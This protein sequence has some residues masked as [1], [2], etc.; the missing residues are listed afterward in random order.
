M[1][2][3]ASR[4]VQGRGIVVV[5]P[6]DLE[7]IRGNTQ[8]FISYVGNM[9]NRINSG[10][11]LS[12]ADASSSM[13]QR[14]TSGP[15]P[16]NNFDPS[17]FN[18]P[19]RLRPEDLRPPPQKRQRNASITGSVS[20]PAGAG[21]PNDARTPRTPANA[22]SPLV[23]DSPAGMTSTRDDPDRPRIGNQR[24]RKSSGSHLENVPEEQHQLG[25]SS[26]GPSFGAV[27]PTANGG[28]SSLGLQVGDRLN[29]T[30][31]ATEDPLAFLEAQW[32]KLQSI[33]SNQ[34]SLAPV[35]AD[36]GLGLPSAFDTAPKSVFV[37]TSSFFTHSNQLAA[38]TTAD[39]APPPA[40]PALVE[41]PFDISYFI[42]D[43]VQ[44]ADDDLQPPTA[45]ADDES[46]PP[47]TAPAL[48]T[49]ASSTDSQAGVTAD[50]SALH[51][52]GRAID[53]QTPDLLHSGGVEESP[54]SI[55]EA[56]SP[57]NAAGYQNTSAA[58]TLSAR[59]T[60]SRPSLD[61]P[62]TT[63]QGT[64]SSLSKSPVLPL[65][66]PVDQLP[67]TMGEETYF[68]GL[69]DDFQ[70]DPAALNVDVNGLPISDGA[71]PWM[72]S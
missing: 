70:F 16:T 55:K 47:P 34:T 26:F 39:V 3:W 28:A 15:L 27:N 12:N 22:G 35:Q 67:W 18:P 5:R 42:S 43:D 52:D 6:R 58:S 72:T 59:S 1:H 56:L 41:E 7:Q 9:M 53:A 64:T 4:C 51:F 29:E 49:K 60:Q 11:S 2:K 57:S 36:L 25:G 30:S 50:M 23:I 10:S 13:P 71:N 48:T 46:A 69:G 63:A 54:A 61:I 68:G 44:Y 40:E 32:S 66:T 62:P 19:N 33:D 45:P 17:S 21:S 31:A 20:S 65:E 24:K 14:S 8:K 38:T 37:S